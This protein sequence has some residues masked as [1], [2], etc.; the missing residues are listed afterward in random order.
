MT[1]AKQ[2]ALFKHYGLSALALAVSVVTAQATLAQEATDKPEGFIEGSTLNI[3]NRNY[4]VNKDFRDKGA[5]YTLN[6]IDKKSGYREEWAHGVM[7][8]Y[9]SGFTQ[10]FVG[11]GLDAHAYGGFK[12]DSGRGRNNKRSYP[13]ALL[14]VDNDGNEE[15]GFGE[16]GGAVKMRVSAT[17]LKYGEMRTTAPVFGTGDSFLLPETATGFL[18]TSNEFEGTKFEAGH[19]TAY[20][21]YNSTNSNDELLLN[22]GT[23]EVGD[24]LDFVGGSYNITDNVH[25]MLYYS[26]FDETWNQYYG[27]LNYTIPLADTQKLVFDANVYRTYDTGDSYQGEISNTTASLE[28]AYTIGAH[29]FTVAQQQVNGDTPYDYVGY[30]SVWISNSML[31]SDFNAPNEMSTSV[32][33]A[34]D[35]TDMGVPGL[36]AEMKYG[37]GHDI[38]GTH[39]DPNGGYADY[40]GANGKHWERDFDIK[41]VVQ[42]GPAKNLSVRLRQATHRANADQ[43]E[44]DLDEVRLIV[45]YPLDVL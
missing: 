18:V 9:Q 41:Y 1:T 4:Y 29:T 20:N 35:F 31:V 45:E 25:A 7:A 33:Y 43:A 8:T 16:V 19:F 17:E 28:A 12:L 14:P 23:G 40:Y 15:D 44:N 2:H 10:G 27:N 13:F 32:A 34:L 11:F 42:S 30:D 22:Y 21:N 38:D 5:D 24:S 3:L 36:T 26:H 37:K 39:A 6:G